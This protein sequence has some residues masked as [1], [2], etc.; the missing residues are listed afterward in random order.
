MGFPT[1]PSDGQQYTS[2]NGSVYEYTAA[3]DRWDRIIIGTIG[4]GGGLSWSAISSNKN[5]VAGEGY[6][7]D[8]SGGTF[9]VTLPG[10]PSIGDTVAIIDSTSSFV[11]NN[12]TIGRNG[13]PIMGLSE[14]LTLDEDNTAIELIY[15]DATNGWRVK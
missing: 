5:A 12:V 2:P 15:S 13:K 3:D 14:D 10:S 9:T 7:A 6:M 4:G 8:S 1:S 11:S